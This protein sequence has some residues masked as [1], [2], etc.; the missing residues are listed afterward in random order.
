MCGS[1]LRSKAKATPRER[2]NIANTCRSPFSLGR[3]AV[4]A[5]SKYSAGRNRL[6]N[7]RRRIRAKCSAYGKGLG[8]FRFAIVAWIRGCGSSSSN[9]AGYKRKSSDDFL[10]G[11]FGIK[12]HR[13]GKLPVKPAIDAWNELRERVGQPDDLPTWEEAGLWT[14]DKLFF[15]K[16]YIDTVTVAMD[17]RKGRSAFP[18]GVVYVDLFGGTGICTLKES[19]KRFPGSA[20]SRQT[21]KSRL[22]RLLCAKRIRNMRM[23][24]EPGCPELPSP[25]DAKY[26]RAT[27]TCGLGR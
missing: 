16:R 20:P 13:R 19:G 8:S 12:C 17:G 2:G 26:L 27:A 7:S 22:R 10:K 9:G 5:N 21:R 25:T 4:G 24:A 18:G 11:K 6:G 14:K 3:A 15:W 1:A 23:L